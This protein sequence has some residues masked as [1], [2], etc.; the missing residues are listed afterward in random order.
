MTDKFRV[1]PRWVVLVFFWIGLVAAVSI[2]SLTLLAHVNPQASV[3][4]WRFAMICYTVFFGYRYWIG[5]RRKR[6]VQENSLI[7]AVRNADALEPTVQRATLYI[8]HSIT[9][10]KE[11]FNYAFICILSMVALVLDLIFQ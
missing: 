2:R 4:V 5:I 6:I 9:R 7:E 8:L 10:S 11:L 3:W 1:L